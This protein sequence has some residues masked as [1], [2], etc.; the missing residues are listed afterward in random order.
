MGFRKL[1]QYKRKKTG[2]LPV[3]PP[4]AGKIKGFEFV[5]KP[6]SVVYGH[7]SRLAVADKLKRYSRYSV[8]RTALYD[9]NPILQR[10]GFTWHTALPRYR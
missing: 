3:L 7:L 10:V 6:S 8:G 4:F 9:G 5:C 1:L 2:A